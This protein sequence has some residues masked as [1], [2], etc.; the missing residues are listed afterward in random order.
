M[1]EVL[2]KLANISDYDD[3]WDGLKSPAV[4]I[5]IRAYVDIT[6]R[7]I[8]TQPIRQPEIYAVAPDKTW[9][10]QNKASSIILEW[11]NESRSII[12]DFLDQ[13]LLFY[14]K[15]ENDVIIDS[16]TINFNY[17]GGFVN[18]MIPLIS[19]CLEVEDGNRTR[20]FNNKNNI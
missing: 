9:S 14:K 12:F 20:N 5:L 6:L 15:L 11:N 2:D 19:W 8:L 18:L 13:D 16:N 1:I 10:P 7:S 3:N 17:N 4:D